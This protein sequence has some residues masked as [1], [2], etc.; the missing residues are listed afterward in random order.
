MRLFDVVEKHISPI[1]THY[2]FAD[3]TQLYISFK[4]DSSTVETDAVAALKACVKDIRNLMVH[5]NLQL[6]DAI[7]EFLIIGTRAQLDKV[8]IN[9]LQV[10]QA[11]SHYS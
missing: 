4:P 10:D 8:T 9:Y 6:N 1:F 3:D 7:T 5:D 2:A 11:C